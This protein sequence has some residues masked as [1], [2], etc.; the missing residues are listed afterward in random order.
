MIQREIRANNVRK[1]RVKLRSFLKG[2]S[3][4]AAFKI[5]SALVRKRKK[6]KEKSMVRGR[7]RGDHTSGRGTRPRCVQATKLLRPLS[8]KFKSK[9]RRRRNFQ[10]LLN[11]VETL[12]PPVTA[13]RRL[14]INP[15]LRAVP[16]RL[17]P[18]LFHLPRSRFPP[19]FNRSENALLTELRGRQILP[20]P[21]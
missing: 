13:A 5:P 17:S 10:S 21:L 7:A 1:H 14:S 6:K 15:L 3:T 4:R 16:P 18:L 2:G 20:Q 8:Y 11:L 19:G 9:P 12:S